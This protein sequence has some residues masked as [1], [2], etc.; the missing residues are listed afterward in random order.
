MAAQNACKQPSITVFRG[1][2]DAGKYVWSPYVTKLET[3]L[4][5]AGVKYTTEA[6]SL[7]VAPKG[8]IPYIECR[9]VSS[10]STPIVHEESPESKVLL[11]DS[12]L[13]AK[14]LV[15]WK[16]LPDLNSALDPLE[17]SLDMG[18]IAL[19]ENKLY[20]LQGWERWIQNYY[21]M[22]D[23][24]L[25]SIPYPIRVLV[26]LI[27]YRK[28]VAMFHSQGTG[29]FTAEEISESR[30]EIWEGL[31]ALLASRS[32][33][34]SSD[35]DKPFWVLGGEHPTEADTCLFGF[36]VSALIC[37]A[38][39]ISQSEVRSFPIL[40]DYAGRIHDHYFPDYEKWAV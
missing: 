24:V 4:R 33:D 14:T 3:R 15:G 20:F 37:T 38:G 35:N 7:S 23:H 40:L 10:I 18:L 29:R 2:K 39:P 28:N 25:W 34:K 5:F 32:S 12:T 19:L 17:R 8:K 16:I 36:I 1:W 22:R 31:S 9:G 13:I 6:G 30:R 21:T 11:S 27:V 26:G